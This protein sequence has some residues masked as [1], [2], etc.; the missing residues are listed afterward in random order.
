MPARRD[1]FCTFVEGNE[2]VSGSDDHLFAQADVT[3]AG[4]T[5]V[6]RCFLDQIPFDV[7]I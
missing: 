2:G 1:N 4:A 5:F 7:I 3:S 6:G